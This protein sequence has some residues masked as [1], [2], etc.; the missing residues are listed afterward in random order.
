VSW[1]DEIC[2]SCGVCC[3]TL[4]IVH[5]TQADLDRLALGY[6]LAPEQ[7][8]PMVRRDGSQFRIVM[9]QH[10]ACAALSARG[11][12]YECQA[13]EHRPGIC[14]EYEC[15][16]LAS[17]KDWIAKRAAGE[18]VDAGS[19]FQ[20]ALDEEELRRQVHALIER[21]RQDYRSDCSQLLEGARGRQYEHLPELMETLS[22]AEFDHRFPP[23]E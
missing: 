11:G 6:R 13:Y 20:G 23:R 19:P 14:R 10:A 16:I 21:M 5:I 2:V 1:L 18:N 7:V 9:D 15:F 12:R 3:T 22:G 4:S 8:E 17:A